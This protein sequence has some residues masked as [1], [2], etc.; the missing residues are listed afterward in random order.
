MSMIT[1]ERDLQ[2]LVRRA[3]HHESVALDT[4]FVWEK[5]YYPQLGL[6]QLALSDEACYLIDPI[7]IGDLS[8]LGD[9][10]ADQAVVKILHDAPQDLAILSRVTGAP[11][12]SIFD[13]R[14]GAG[15]AGLSATISLVDL[16]ST[17]LS[18]LLPKSETRTNWLAR[19]LDPSQIAYA[20]DD[21][22]YL[23]AART[24]LLSRIV[25][26][27]VNGWL[28]EEM[29]LLS[30]AETRNGIDD[31]E[32]FRKVK[33]AGSLDGA[34]LAI[35]QELAAWRE[36]EARRVD[37]PRGHVLADA[38]LLELARRRCATPAE[39][40]GTRLLTPRQLTRF[41]RP[42]LACMTAGVAT[43]E[44]ARPEPNRPLRLNGA[45]RAV[46]DRLLAYVR[47]TGESLGIDPQLVGTTA[48]LKQLAKNLTAGDQPMPD[49]LAGGWRRSFLEEF[50]RQR[51]HRHP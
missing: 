14:V 36:E 48:E 44:D 5:T 11:P 23:G 38:I 6:I 10:L 41:G 33:G 50:L 15:F 3:R 51:R 19:P 4:E 26:P 40:E 42:L 17:L 27:D 45:Q 30:R 46:Y 13:T 12:A 20:L 35:L 28:R 8:A 2:E 22:R 7:A 43:G 9:L 32:R 29:M 31:R 1:T 24:L 18:I 39:L 21:V 37:R 49:R 34:D 16:L 25:S 47:K